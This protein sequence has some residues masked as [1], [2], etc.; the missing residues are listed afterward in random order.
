MLQVKAFFATPA[1]TREV[2]PLELPSLCH[3]RE[4]LYAARAVY[5]QLLTQ[6]QT[7]GAA[8]D[9]A[10]HSGNG[11]ANTKTP[12][13]GKASSRPADA[14]TK[15]PQDPG[16]GDHGATV[17]AFGVAPD[18]A[19]PNGDSDE[20]IEAPAVEANT[21]AVEASEQRAAGAPAAGTGKQ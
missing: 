13:E 15:E 17:T 3:V 18:N 16:V 7:N 20:S 4:I 12:R 21:R 6:V 5:Q 11:A 19:R 2:Q 8:H 10:D 9:A 14:G 1:T